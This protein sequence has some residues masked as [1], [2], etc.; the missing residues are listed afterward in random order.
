MKQSE[1]DG[2]IFFYGGERRSYLWTP[3]M[4]GVSEAGHEKLAYYHWVQL[5][6]YSFSDAAGIEK[7]KPKTRK[8]LLRTK[9]CPARYFLWFI[10]SLAVDMLPHTS[11]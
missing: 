9:V 7:S 1:V 5:L 8:L 3:Q 2:Y 10:V 11:L 4:A 6:P